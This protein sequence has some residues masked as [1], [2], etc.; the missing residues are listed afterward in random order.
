MLTLGVVLGI[1]ATLVIQIFFINH[2]T[3]ANNTPATGDLITISMN[4]ALLTTGMRLAIQREQSK[5]PVQLNNINAVTHDGNQLDLNAS[6]PTI[7]NINVSV[8]FTL[9]PSVNKG[10]LN[11]H[12]V[13]AQLGGLSLP[14]ISN[15]IESVLNDQFADFGQ[16][17]L[18]QGLNYQLI[19]VHTNKNALLVTAKL[20]QGS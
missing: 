7:A 8:S 13:D 15:I 20:I 18:V 2:P 11:F 3:S 5:L 4:D 16:G 19:D 10:K 12:V 1:I 17:Q 6:A 9:S 14:G